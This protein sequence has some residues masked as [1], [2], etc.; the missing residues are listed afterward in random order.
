MNNNIKQK[1]FSFLY[2]LDR[3]SESALKTSA[4]TSDK[5]KIVNKSD[6][7]N[8]DRK[9]KLDFSVGNDEIIRDVSNILG[10][11]KSPLYNI[12]IFKTGFCTLR[13]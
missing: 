4:K 8:E 13:I 5:D 7:E 12:F 10:K 11:V 1:R 3:I 2:R 6:K 9:A